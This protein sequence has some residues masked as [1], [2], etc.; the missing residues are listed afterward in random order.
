MIVRL[1]AT[2]LAVGLLGGTAHA[3]TVEHVTIKGA[4]DEI[5]IP[6]NW[7]GSVFL[8]AHGY[9]ADKR[10]L[11]PIP[12]DLSQVNTLLLPGLVLVP[13]GAAAAVTTF[14]SVGWYVKDAIKDIENLRRYFV[15][16]HGKPKHT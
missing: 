4:Q 7:N 13:P 2:I 12:D 15:K 3:R 5:L 8:Y 1:L 6:D 9:T 10:I 14:R 11:E 16:K